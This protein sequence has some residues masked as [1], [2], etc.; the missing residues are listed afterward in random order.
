M[1]KIPI[2]RRR[3]LTAVSFLVLLWFAA[4]GDTGALRVMAFALAFWVPFSIHL[5]WKI[6]DANADEKRNRCT[7]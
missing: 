4:T 2:G 3:A 1:F 7:D 5:F 6:A